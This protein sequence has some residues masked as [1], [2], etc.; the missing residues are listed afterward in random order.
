MSLKFKTELRMKFVYLLFNTLLNKAALGVLSTG[1]H[2]RS[3]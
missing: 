3:L 1:K 2:D